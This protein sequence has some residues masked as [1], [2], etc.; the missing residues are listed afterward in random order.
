M[1]SGEHFALSQYELNH[2][3]NHT[4]AL[5]MNCAKMLEVEHGYSGGEEMFEGD[6]T[7]S[8]VW[9][10]TQKNLWWKKDTIND[11]GKGV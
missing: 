8:I 2:S 10:S 3:S 11:M 6:T 4:L 1:G 9:G 7:L 5:K